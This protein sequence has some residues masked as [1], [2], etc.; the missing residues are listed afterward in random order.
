MG[1]KVAPNS[2]RKITIQKKHSLDVAS[3][4]GV[5]ATDEMIHASERPVY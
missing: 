1:K 2:E 3:K 4:Q 5:K